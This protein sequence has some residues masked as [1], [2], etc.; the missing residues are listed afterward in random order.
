M[1]PE[2]VTLGNLTPASDIYTFGA[3]LYRLLTGQCVFLGE[4]QEQIRQKLSEPPPSVSLNMV[5][6][7]HPK[8]LE[9]L[10]RACLQ[11]L[12]EHRP[13]SA[14]ALRKRLE[15]IHRQLVNTATKSPETTVNDVSVPD[16]LESGFS[17]NASGS[18]GNQGSQSSGQL[19]LQGSHD[20]SQRP[21]FALDTEPNA[22]SLIKPH[23][24]LQTQSDSLEL[25]VSRTIEQV[26][27]AMKPSSPELDINI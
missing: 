26:A 3:T 15:H 4:P 20:D 21:A 5:S 17:H 16:W 23:L 7:S 6:G 11:R 27:P 9:E 2:Q 8:A 25:D 1:S 24:A 19:E 22:P 18:L 14:Q 13:S 10:V 12:P